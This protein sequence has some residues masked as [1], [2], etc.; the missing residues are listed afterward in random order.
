MTILLRNTR[1]DFFDVDTNW[2]LLF[3]QTDYV[4]FFLTVIFINNIVSFLAFNVF[5]EVSFL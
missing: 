1:P 2:L 5:W 4:K 3:I